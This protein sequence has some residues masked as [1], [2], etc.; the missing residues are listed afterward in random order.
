[1]C[2]ISDHKL[3]L[4]TL[5]KVRHIGLE[6]RSR[7]L[8]QSLISAHF[9]VSSEGSSA[10]ST[11]PR[12]IAAA[13]GFTT[14]R[15]TASTATS[16]PGPSPSPSRNGQGSLSLSTAAKVGLSVGAAVGGLTVV[17]LLS[18]FISRRK[19]QQRRA[20]PRRTRETVQLAPDR[21]QLRGVEKNRVQIRQKTPVELPSNAPQKQAWKHYPAAENPP[22]SPH[23]KDNWF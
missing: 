2:R 5:Q 20:A 16:S 17:V 8:I 6:T 4:S 7:V 14:A 18:G 3:L 12:S 11:M 21:K 15:A 13:T 9:P 19:K 22:R 1:M 23:D 10:P